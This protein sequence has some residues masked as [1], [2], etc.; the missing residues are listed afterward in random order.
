M[1]YLAGYRAGLQDFR[2][3]SVEIEQLQTRTCAD[4]SPGK[5]A[6][7]CG[8]HASEL[9]GDL[10]EGCHGEGKKLG[11]NVVHQILANYTVDHPESLKE[12]FPIVYKAA[13]DE[14]FP[15]QPGIK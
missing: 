12:P 1:M 6:D 10:F 5:V 9:A 11:A 8:L 14:A 15:C 7:I 4:S 13:M 3:Q 2:S